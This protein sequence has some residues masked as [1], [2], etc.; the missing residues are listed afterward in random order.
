MQILNRM[1]LQ[2]TVTI[3]AL[4]CLTAGMASVYFWQ[5]AYS[6]L[7]K[8]Y[9]NAYS[10]GLELYQASHRKEYNNLKRQGVSVDI[11]QAQEKFDTKNQLILDFQKIKAGYE[12][13]EL[14]FHTH[15]SSQLTQIRIYKLY[16]KFKV[17]NLKNSVS[18]ADQFG[19]LSLALAQKCDDT[20]VVLNIDKDN[21]ALISA[22][23]YWACSSK[24]FDQRWISIVIFIIS[25]LVVF[26]ASQNIP[27]PFVTLARVFKNK[28]HYSDISRMELKGTIET[29]SLAKSLNNFIE[30]EDKKLEKRIKFF[31]AMSHDLGTPITRLRLRVDLIED[32]VLKQKLIK[33]VDHLTSMISASLHFMRHEVEKEPP[34]IVDFG[35]LVETI[36]NNYQDMD[37]SVLYQ[38][39]SKISFKTVGSLFGNSSDAEI[40]DISDRRLITGSCQPLNMR[41]AIENL[42]DNGLKFGDSVIIS[43]EADSEFIYI[44]VKDDGGGVAPQEIDKIASA[45]FQGANAKLR[46]EEPIGFGNVGLGLAIVGA[47]VD[48]HEGQVSFHNDPEVGGFVVSLK[49]PRRLNII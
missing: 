29:Q 27:Q 17:S 16:N 13:S 30:I 24:P 12:F 18:D 9:L 14:N 22:P 3:L 15:L 11:D 19:N 2:L 42:I 1:S 5:K 46:T 39:P 8:Y 38:P 47:I 6:E 21:W 10:F 45:F 26:L 7:D 20:I 34:R 48:A 31:T 36:A 43:L 4:F 35:S 28:I 32:Q 33:D 25:L 41:R 44:I 40:K 49:L 37:L 23:I